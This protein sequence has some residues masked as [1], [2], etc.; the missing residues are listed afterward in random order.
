M[1]RLLRGKVSSCVISVSVN[2]GFELDVR[3]V[4]C[5]VCHQQCM[6]EDNSW[7]LVVCS[8]VNECAL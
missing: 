8:W 7:D 6:G 3:N 5:L 4:S 2:V 1:V